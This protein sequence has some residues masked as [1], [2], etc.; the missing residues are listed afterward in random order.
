MVDVVARSI[1]T[2]AF[3]RTLT[4][5]RNINTLQLYPSIPFFFICDFY[6]LY[7]TI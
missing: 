7:N 4:L 2:K 1:K 6:T 3:E 5:V